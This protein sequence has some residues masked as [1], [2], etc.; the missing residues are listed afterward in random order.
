M[1][2]RICGVHIAWRYRLVLLVQTTAVTAHE[3]VNDIALPARITQRDNGE[4]KFE[5]ST[6]KIYRFRN[7]YNSTD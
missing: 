3:P 7:T 1:A 2:A 5:V 4:L 6:Y